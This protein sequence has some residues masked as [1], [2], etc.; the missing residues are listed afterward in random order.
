MISRKNV[1]ESRDFE[2]FGDIKKVGDRY[3]ILIICLSLIVTETE[4]S[5]VQNTN[6]FAH[7]RFRQ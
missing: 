7:L 2:E 3:L 6:K 1:Q 4:S 5:V